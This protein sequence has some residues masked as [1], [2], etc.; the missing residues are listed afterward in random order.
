MTHVK[1]ESL[2]MPDVLLT[3]EELQEKL[4]SESNIRVVDGSWQFPVTGRDPRKEYEEAHIPGAVFFNIDGCCD[5]FSKY[6]NMLPTAEEFGKFVEELGID[7]DTW[8]V[9]YDN[10]DMGMFSAQRVWWTFRVYG[11]DKV[12]ILN[13]GLPK[14]KEAGLPTES[15]VTKVK[16]TT[17][18]ATYKPEMVKTFEEVERNI[19]EKT[20]QLLDARPPGRFNGSAPEPR[21]DIESGHIPG[22]VNVPFGMILDP[23][24]K[25]VKNVEA[26][27]KTFDTKGVDLSKPVVVSCGSGMTATGLYLAALLCGKTDVQVY[28]G[29]W[30]EWYFRSKPEQRVKS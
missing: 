11:H 20:F 24:S 3:P 25:T 16:K 29:A 17:F 9:V 28:D 2:K 13:G 23:A 4:K 27:R 14:W 19:K 6:D 22:A 15:G 5:T 8:V 10:S 21:A 18:K 12:S 7:N 30:T 1:S 26:L